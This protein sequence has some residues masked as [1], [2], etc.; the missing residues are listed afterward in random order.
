MIHIHQLPS[1]KT[2]TL[3]CVPNAHYILQACHA[4]YTGW[5]CIKPIL[6]RNWLPISCVLSNLHV[7]WVFKICV[8]QCRSWFLLV[9]VHR[10]FYDPLPQNNTHIHIYVSLAILYIVLSATPSSDPYKACKVLPT[11]HSTIFCQL[12]A[13]SHDSVDDIA[14]FTLQPSLCPLCCVAHVFL[15]RFFL[16]CFL[17]LCPATVTRLWSIV[18]WQK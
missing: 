15:H 12:R 1:C 14:G 2:F 5:T 9:S 11:F 18:V 10:G 7:S 16:Y 8:M 17:L 6:K 3:H 4:D 13:C